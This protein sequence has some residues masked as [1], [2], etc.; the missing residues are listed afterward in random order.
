M[1]GA[2]IAAPDTGTAPT[3]GAG[4]S[5]KGSIT[6]GQWAQDVLA[7]DDTG[8]APVIF[9][10]A[11]KR[12]RHLP[13]GQD[14]AAW[15]DSWAGRPKSVFRRGHF[16][17]GRAAR[18][19]TQANSKRYM[20]TLT[21]T[22][23]I[24]RSTPTR[25]PQCGHS[26]NS[27]GRLAFL[28]ATSSN[29]GRGV[30]G[31]WA[32]NEPIGA[33]EYVALSNRLA[34]LAKTHGL[35]ID[36]AVMG[37]AARIMRLPGTV[38][39]KNGAVCAA[40]RT[41]AKFYSP[42]DLDRL[43]PAAVIGTASR[44]FTA[45]QTGINADVTGADF[46]PADAQ[47]MVSECGALGDVV[48]SRGDVLEPLW[49]AMLG[50]V[51]F[52]TDGESVAHEM[53][54][55]DP[56]YS[57]A[58]TQAKLDAWKTGPTTCAEFAKHAPK[59]CEACKHKGKITSPIQLGRTAQ[60]T[61]GTAGTASTADVPLGGGVD[62]GARRCAPRVGCCDPRSANPGRNARRGQARAGLSRRSG[63]PAD[64]QWPTRPR[65][66]ERRQGAATRRSVACTS[67]VQEVRGCGIRAGRVGRS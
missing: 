65:R 57:H 53:S 9:A 36:P 30:H 38:N 26:G 58:E 8:G 10:L 51:K 40:S 42:A 47:R 14:F 16:P 35:L 5:A 21:A 56:R 15:A 48:A 18:R 55:G 19:R 32:L 37:D 39:S 45:D 52:A 27:R 4:S 33:A 6:A 31:Y 11:D 62:A 29:S 46:A 63:I 2:V 60:G 1:T 34:Q 7:L 28:L 64:A 17:R 59:A 43:L 67:G 50:A 44:S 54:R 61:T 13:R 41:G 23:M 12:H 49:R 22:P 20:W 66:K 24:L 3:A 25:S